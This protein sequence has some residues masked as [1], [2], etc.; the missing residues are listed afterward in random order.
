[1]YEEK[2]QK[3]ISN[4]EKV[5]SLVKEFNEFTLPEEVDDILSWSGALYLFA[6]DILSQSEQR[7]KA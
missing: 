6:E 3:I 7:Q 2:I 5:I 4:F 1:M